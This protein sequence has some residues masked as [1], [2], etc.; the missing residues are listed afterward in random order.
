[1][2]HRI[3]P[4]F[5][6]LLMLASSC[7][8][9]LNGKYQTISFSTDNPETKIYVND[10]L[11]GEGG[12][13]DYELE[14][15]GNAKQVRVELDG[16]KSEYLALYPNQ[17]SPL[18]IISWLPPFCLCGAWAFDLG[19]KSFNY[20]KEVRF[21]PDYRNLV[22][23][24][25]EQK[26]IFPVKT[27]FEVDKE[28]LFFEN[29]SIKKDGST[30]QTFSI[31][32]DESVEITNT[33]FTDAIEETLS[34]YGYLDSTKTIFRDKSNTLY[35]DAAVQK[36]TFRRFES[37]ASDASFQD[38]ELSINWKILDYYQLPKYE[39]ELTVP[40]GQFA[41]D[42]FEEADDFFVALFQDAISNSFLD[43]M[44]SAEIKELLD[45]EVKLIPDY[46]VL[47]LTR[48]SKIIQDLGQAQ[49]ATVT[50]EH[51]E[52]HGSGCVVSEDGYIVTNYHVI[53]G[54]DELTVT[55]NS[56][57]KVPATVT[58][59]NEGSDLALLKVEQTFDYAY[60][61]FGDA[62]YG[63]GEEVYAIGTPKSVELGQTLSKGIISG[64]R[65][66]ASYNWIQTDVSISPGNSGGALVSPDGKLLG[67]VN[68][69]LMGRGVEGIAFCIP[70]GEIFTMLKLSY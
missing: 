38:V 12:Y 17:R 35:V 25:E 51:E 21:A 52:G 46:E 27:S 29:Y 69:K 30:Q 3:L 14:R 48:S 28:S 50:I 53:A 22:D 24:Q 49:K 58:R 20:D 59:V 23:R 1:M 40:S 5:L 54:Q 41:G 57:E 4:L 16:Y 66:Q 33:I 6:G 42:A 61:V 15:D 34:E 65:K 10:E 26:Y 31:S 47:S 70:V 37:S 18:Y 13:F 11:I 63:V 67:I 43:L 9:T 62:E 8:T 55:L 36:I 44:K 2:S 45:E 19:P 64:V 60:L 68:S 56:G 39:T 32:G 7:A